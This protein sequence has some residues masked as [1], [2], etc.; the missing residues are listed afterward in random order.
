MKGMFLAS[1]ELAVV[2][3]MDTKWLITNS[4]TL[5]DVLFVIW[6]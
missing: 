5:K 2:G 6:L 4:L 1:M 3:T